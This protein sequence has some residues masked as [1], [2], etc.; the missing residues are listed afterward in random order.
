MFVSRT[1]HDPLKCGGCGGETFTLANVRWADE[2]R[3]VF[4]KIRVT[5]AKCRS[6]SVIRVS[7]RLEIEGVKGDGTLCGG[8]NG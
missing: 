5:C 3:D 1:V 7:A 6:V 2:G 4:G 8:W